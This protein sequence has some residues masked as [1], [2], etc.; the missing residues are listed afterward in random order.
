[1]TTRSLIFSLVALLVAVSSAAAGQVRVS[2]AASLSDALRE[3]AVEFTKEHPQVQL[4]PNFGASGALTRQIAQGAPADLFL[5]AH[6]KW[7]DYLVEQGLIEAKN[8]QTL[9]G[10][11]LVFAG[12]RNSDVSGLSDLPR[13]AR[14]AIASPASAPAGQ[15]AEQALARAGILRALEGKLV[16]AQ[17][18]RQAL[19]YADRGEVDGAFVYRTDAL[20]AQQAVILFTVAGDL[21][22][23]VSYPL[24]LTSSGEKN[25][26]A[27]AFA[28]FLKTARVKAILSRAGFTVN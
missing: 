9:A 23:P 28:D 14:I 1:M 3:I 16:Q 12:R 20:P 15:Y 24:A 2:A 27:V 19:V 10:N 5:S 4:L 13:L 25:P 26:E 22:D 8:V 21:H 7:M 17:D 11:A 18:V 6:P